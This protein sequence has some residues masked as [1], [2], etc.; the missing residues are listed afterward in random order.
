MVLTGRKDRELEF[1][2]QNSKKPADRRKKAAM[3]ANLQESVM[4]NKR[5]DIL[6]NE[7]GKETILY[8]YTDEAIHVL[9]A[10]ARLIWDLCDGEHSFETIERALRDRFS[11]P[12]GQDVGA[13]VLRTIEIFAQK[14]LLQ[15][16]E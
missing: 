16:S 9:N 10:T 1:F 4:P 7:T 6:E 14:G 5:P 3:C 8:S 11:V 12:A 15:E 2:V 13:D